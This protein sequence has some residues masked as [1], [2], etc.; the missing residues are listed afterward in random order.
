WY[1]FEESQKPEVQYEAKPTKYMK[2]VN[3]RNF[4]LKKS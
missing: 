2:I 3:Q 4:F 1:F